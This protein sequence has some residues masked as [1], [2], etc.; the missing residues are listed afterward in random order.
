LAHLARSITSQASATQ[1]GASGTGYGQRPSHTRDSEE[2]LTSQTQHQTPP[3]QEP[4]RTGPAISITSDHH[5]RLLASRTTKLRISFSP[6]KKFQYGKSIP[7]HK[8]GYGGLLNTYWI[9]VLSLH[10]VDWFQELHCRARLTASIC[11]RRLS[12]KFA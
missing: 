7:E 8:A 12:F 9:E 6:S 1:Q 5:H 11:I 2:W 10:I 3:S 4:G